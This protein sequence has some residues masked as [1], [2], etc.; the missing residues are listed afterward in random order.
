MMAMDAQVQAAGADRNK[1]KLQIYD[2]LRAK[3]MENEAD[4][5]MTYDV[6]VR[7]NMSQPPNITYNF[8]N[9]SIAMANFGTQIGSISASL[10]AIGGDDQRSRDFAL[11]L[12]LLTEGVVNSDLTEQQKKEALDKFSF[13]GKQGEEPPEKR[14]TGVLK[15]V[16]ESIPNVLGTAA[17][18]L[19]LWQTFGS[20]ITKFFGF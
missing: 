14:Q 18:L 3:G 10:S 20:H 5:L 1:I 8:N 2:A 17:S 9:N 15:P 12:K 6:I 19:T 11:A 13:V 16:L 7:A 4:L